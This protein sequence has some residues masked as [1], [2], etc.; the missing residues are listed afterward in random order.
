[1]GASA[2]RRPGEWNLRALSFVAVAHGVSD[3]FAGMIPLVI[4]FVIARDQLS[5]V[6]QGLLGFLWYFTSSIVQPFFGAYADRHGRWWFLPS[7]ILLTVTSLSLAGSVHSLALLAL[8]IVVGGLGSA[9]MH[10]EAGKYSAMLSGARKAGGISI[11]QI[12]GQFGFALG[13]IVIAPLLAHFGGAGA[14]YLLPPMV[15]VAC[16]IFATM[17][18]VD[19]AAYGGTRPEFTAPVV[20]ERV[21]RFGLTLLIVSTALRQFVTGAF[22]TFLP[23]VLAARGFTL[24]QSGELVSAFLMVSVAGLYAGGALAD[25]F[26]ALRVC[27]A[28]LCGAVPLLVL[29]FAFPGSLGI[30]FLLCGS[31]LLAMQ[32]APGVALVQGML[33]RNLGMALG[34]MNGVAFGVGSMFVALTGF[35]GV[36]IG[37]DAALVQVSYVPLL[38]ALSMLAVGRRAAE[39]KAA[40]RSS[41]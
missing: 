12:G 17:P 3:F 24:T 16:A 7:A 22:M 15:L 18:G 38:A 14:L 6:Y 41:N 26:G 40:A 39:R 5:P 34:L 25:R 13:P 9:V 27:V 8:C 23:N 2:A 35:V 1:L 37:F 29:F 20:H 19:R 11:F 30:A 36:R 33:P 4:Y 28:S 10:P 32:N 21:D 31:V